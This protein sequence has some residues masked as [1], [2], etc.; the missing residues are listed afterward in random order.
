ME[1]LL[2][3]D[4]LALLSNTP[5]NLPEKCKIVSPLQ[6]AC[7]HSPLT[8]EMNF[9]VPFPLLTARTDRLRI[10]AGGGEKKKIRMRPVHPVPPDSCCV[11]N[12]TAPHSLVRHHLSLSLSPEIQ[13]C[14]SDY[15]EIF[16]LIKQTC[17]NGVHSNDHMDGRDAGW[18]VTTAPGIPDSSR[19]SALQTPRDSG[20][21]VRR[22]T[23]S[24]YKRC[25]GVGG[26]EDS[27]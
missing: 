25:I 20:Y 11:D 27:R 12:S 21:R 16:Y 26:V 24:R 13:N 17:V 8:L 19:P 10:G 15:T 9:S 22:A 18:A 4:L 23:S 2:A 6:V 5:E 7:K 14:C 1:I 3:S